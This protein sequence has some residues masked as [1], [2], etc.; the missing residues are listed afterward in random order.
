MNQKTPQFWTRLLRFFCKESLHEE[1]QGDLEESFYSNIETK[2]L[3]K[4]KAIYR[5][6]VLKMLRP[7]VIKKPKGFNSKIN[8][9][10]FK[11][12]FVLTLRNIQRNKVFSLVNILGLGAALTI[13]LFCV[14][15]IYTGFQ[16][17]SHHKDADRIYRITTNVESSISSMHFASS[18]FAL[19]WKMPDIPQVETTTTFL[20]GLGYSFNIKGENI[21]THGYAVDENFLSVFDFKTVEG[22]PNDIFDDFASIIITDKA[23]K[24]IF[25][26]ESP[27]GKQNSGGHIV[28]AVIESPDEKSHLKF[29]FLHNIEVMGRSMSTDEINTRLNRWDSYEHG[30][31]TYFKLAQNSTL[32]DFNIQLATLNTEMNSDLDDGKQYTMKAQSLSDIMF[33]PQ[34]IMDFQNVY[35]RITLILLVVPI[36]VLIS[37]ASFNY[38]NLSIARAIQRSKEIGIR[39]ITGSSK[40]QIISQFL[41]ET[42]MFSLFA[43]VIALLSYQYLSISF[44]AYIQEFSELYTSSLNAEI[45]GWFIAFSLFV[46]LVAGILP[47]LHFAQVSPLSAMRNQVKNGALSM[48]TMRKILVGLQLGVS[49]FFVLFIALIADQKTQIMNADLGFVSEGLITI[50]I[51]EVDIDLLTAEFDKIPEIT[52][53]SA[54]SM[55]PGTGGLARRFITSENYA[56]TIA[57]GYGV[58]DFK[59]N[60]VYKPQLAAGFGFSP[61]GKNEII[62]DDRILKAF[63]LPLDSAIGSIIHLMQ[64]DIEENLEVVGVL[65]NYISDGLTSSQMPLI[66]RN[67]RDTALT[68]LITINISTTNV[69]EALGKIEAGWNAVAQGKDFEPVY[70]DDAIEEGYAPFFNFMNLLTLAGIAVIV[71]AVLGQF[72]MALYNAES[73]V[74]EIGIRK[75]LG[76]TFYSIARLFSLGTLKS[77]IISGLIAIPLIYLVFREMIVPSF[78]MQLEISELTLIATLL[79]LWG[80][81]IGIV[82]TQ[83]WQT[84]KANPSESLRSE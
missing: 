43:L 45:I 49:T 44:G 22:D 71:I 39:K 40:A 68:N 76:A 19:K 34:L 9:S 20:F 3:K 2:G 50:P 58:A 16:F 84:A 67:Q 42:T 15:M 60:N 4:A 59:F 54:S 69:N 52:N 72:G 82:T 26:N 73:R 33:G 8:T 30:R 66:I 83:T 31:F 37:L 28:R 56:D 11:L 46:G 1:L 7:S 57:T 81:V 62:V 77:L 32:K 21:S 74:K 38:T 51:K 25:G 53:Y 64:Y 6:E 61:E 65:G 78:A 27:I 63:Q 79:S 14:N 48:S 36:I 80:I 29:D 24:R 55:T 75:V 35:P 13:C 18:P 10:L 12:H 5:Q 17:D 41:L 70:V 47:A 23:A